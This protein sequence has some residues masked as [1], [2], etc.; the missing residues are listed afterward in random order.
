M[1]VPRVVWSTSGRGHLWSGPLWLR[2][3]RGNT[4]ENRPKFNEIGKNHRLYPTMQ[5]ELETV[6]Y[7]Y[8]P[9]LGA[10]FQ[11][12]GAPIIV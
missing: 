11:G 7:L 1:A 9:P 12:K 8:P 6:K 3:T 5:I 10:F 4:P 2:A